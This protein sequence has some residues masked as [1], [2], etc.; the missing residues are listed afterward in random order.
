MK[1]MG[2]KARFA[3]EI[4]PI[5]LEGRTK[6]QFYVEP[7]AGGMN[8]ID[9]VKGFR[10]ASDNN[11][12]LI[13]MWLGINNGLDFPME[14]DKELYSLARDTFRGKNENDMSDALIGWIGFMG[15]ANGRFFDGG[16]SGKSVT[17]DGSVRDY[18]SESIRNIK[19]QI[20]YMKNVSFSSRSYDDLFIPSNSIIYCDIPYSGTKQYSTSKGFDHGLFWDWAREKS[21]DNSVFISEYS[22]PDDFE[23]IWEKQAKSSLSANGKFG[24]N[25]VST[26]KLFKYKG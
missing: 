24:G 12:Y 8:M 2:S 13:A 6:M 11:K 18:I 15:S 4:L 7:F 21:Q 14:I 5:I 26:E 10:I 23:C 16:Y 19:K 1:Y 25:K 3:K 20:P 9:K 17:K 22:A